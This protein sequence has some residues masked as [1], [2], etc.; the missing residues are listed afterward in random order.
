MDKGWD[1]QAAHSRQAGGM[2]WARELQQG[3]SGTGPRRDGFRGVSRARQRFFG[4]GAEDR[5]GGRKADML[6]GIREEARFKRFRRLQRPNMQ[7]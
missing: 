5:A 4:L 6:E 2:V 1:L 3:A 7:G